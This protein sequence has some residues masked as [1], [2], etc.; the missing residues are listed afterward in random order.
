MVRELLA[1]IISISVVAFPGGTGAGCVTCACVAC[2]KNN[3]V[4]SRIIL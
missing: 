1:K 3:P 2:I 4:I